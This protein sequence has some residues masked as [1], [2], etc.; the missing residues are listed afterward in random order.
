MT[1]FTE[2]RILIFF[3]GLCGYAW[4][5]ILALSPTQLKGKLKWPSEITSLMAHYT[6]SLMSFA[7]KEKECGQT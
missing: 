3:I 2:L 1:I 6:C 7:S 4:V 5:T